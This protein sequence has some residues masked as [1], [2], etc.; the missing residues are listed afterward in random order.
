MAGWLCATGRVG[1]GRGQLR[2]AQH[3]PRYRHTTPLPVLLSI[4]SHLRT[5]LPLPQAFLPQA[6]S[7]IHTHT[8][9]H[10]HLLLLPETASH[11]HSLYFANRDWDFHDGAAVR[12]NLGNDEAPHAVASARLI[13]TLLATMKKW[14]SGGWLWV[15]VGGWGGWVGGH[16][17]RILAVQGTTQ[18][19]GRG[20]YIRARAGMTRTP[21]A[22][23]LG[24]AV[25]VAVE[26]CPSCC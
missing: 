5:R 26:A 20:A 9:T 17:G 21:V 19:A 13:V 2:P 11:T 16:G 14:L 24:P 8:H 10:T 12:S 25:E 3:R 22:N 1:R 23:E 4:S 6:L 15:V 18:G 7:Y